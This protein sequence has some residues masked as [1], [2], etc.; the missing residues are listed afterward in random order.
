MVLSIFGGI[1]GD[2]GH[3]VSGPRNSVLPACSNP[4]T[5][6]HDYTGLLGL[7]S[8]LARVPSGHPASCRPR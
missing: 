5:Y 1:G 6:L 3:H 4:E 7:R 8:P 2:A